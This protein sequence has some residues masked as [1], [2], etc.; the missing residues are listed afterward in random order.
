MSQVGTA[1]SS[2]PR[3][4]RFLS[5][6]SIAIDDES[7]APLVARL[8]QDA[9]LNQPPELK[10][11]QFAGQKS[12]SRLRELAALL[13]PD[14]ALGGR[15]NIYLID[16]H[17]FVTAKIIDLLLEEEANA[18]GINLY[19]GDLAQ[20]LAWTLFH[21]GPRTLGPEGFDRLI[22]AMVGF[23]SRR[24]RDGS[25]VGVDALFEQFRQALARSH[26]RQVTDILTALL[27]TRAY[28]EE[29]LRDLGSG[30]LL[31]AM[32]PLIPSLPAIGHWWSRQIGG[33][34]ML[35]DEHKVLTDYVLG[36]IASRA[37]LDVKLSRPEMGARRRPQSRAVRAVRRGVSRHHPSIQLADLVAGAGQAIA[38]RHAGI[39]SPAGDLLYTTVVPLINAESM[40]PYKSISCFA[41][42]GAISE[43]TRR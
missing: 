42:A 10:F 31:S 11:A 12:G 5:I 37:A 2:T 32:E 21:E 23:A 25:V 40:V 4:D 41:D 6:G 27:R 14:G 39:G 36:I 43:P 34:S 26:R 15:V 9:A 30:G 20:R 7:A 38:R 3:A 33:M 8:R 13:A 22:A 29:F 24:N 28:A 1:N 35:V 19:G 18:R 16:E 17:W